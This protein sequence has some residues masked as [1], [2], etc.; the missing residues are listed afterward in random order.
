MGISIGLSRLFYQLNEAGIISGN[1]KATPTDILIVPMNDT[2]EYALSIASSLRARGISAEVYLNGGKM[3]KK[4]SYANKLGIP[5]VAV[6]GESEMQSG[7]VML[8][9]M[10]TGEQD[11]VEAENI[12]VGRV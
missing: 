2:V 5:Y 10:I 3:G 9:N 12:F 4:L 1:G 7:T 11:E 6:A 8:K